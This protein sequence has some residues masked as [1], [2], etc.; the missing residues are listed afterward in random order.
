MLTEDIYNPSNIGWYYSF[1]Y[2]PNL[3]AIKQELIQLNSNKDV[4]FYSTN[5]YY[6]NILKE[7]IIACPYLLEYLKSTGLYSIFSRVLFSQSVPADASKIHTDGNYQCPS[8]HSLNIPLLH[9]ANSYTV[10][11]HSTDPIYALNPGYSALLDNT[12]AV[13]LLRVEVTSPMIINTT[14]L[15]K[16]ISSDPNRLI[17]GIRFTRP[18]SSQEMNNLG[19]SNP[20]IQL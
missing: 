7:N 9:Y 16:G 18:L 4:I 8:K 20:F 10:W 6:K 13:E 15:H 1:I 2:I 12:N 19:V 3:E 11:Y 14:I 17:C 5:K